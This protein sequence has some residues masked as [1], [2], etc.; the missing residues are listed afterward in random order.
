MKLEDI[1]PGLH[2]KNEEYW[3][4]YVLRDV[5]KVFGKAF[6]IDTGSTDRTV[7][8]AKETANAIGA[9]L[10][11]FEFDF[12]NN[13]TKIGNCSNLLRGLISTEWMFL[14]DGDEIWREDILRK[15]ID[16]TPGDCPVIMVGGRNI[17]VREGVMMER[18]NDIANYD[19][20]FRRGLH[21]TGEY[22]FQGYGLNETVSLASVHYVDAQ[23]IFH[24]HV[25]NTVRS[26]DN[27]KAHFRKT[28]ADF[29]PYSGP[30]NPMPK[31][32]L[33]EIATQWHNPYVND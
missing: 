14:V 23:D 5:L 9:E 7:Q 30:Y 12:D 17:D 2:V 4:H 33:G 21:W 25:R 24:W 28:K 32:W 18:T 6:M 31:N 27:V 11:L 10:F 26:S 29:F 20:L 16:I 13:P 8:I 19:R 22:P 3:I 15:F 1:T